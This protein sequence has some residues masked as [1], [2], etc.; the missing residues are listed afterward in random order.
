MRSPNLA[1]ICLRSLEGAYLQLE[2]AD[3]RSVGVACEVLPL[4]LSIL[5]HHRSSQRG[6]GGTRLQYDVVRLNR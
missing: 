2:D 4:L 3:L 1:D 5:L 6:L